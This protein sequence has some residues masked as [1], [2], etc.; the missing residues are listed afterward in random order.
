[1]PGPAGRRPAA[2]ATLSIG[3][4]RALPAS[5]PGE[6]LPGARLACCTWFGSSTLLTDPSYL[7]CRSRGSLTSRPLYHR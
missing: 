5:F 4:A 3:L 2:E 7:H 1:M 6:L